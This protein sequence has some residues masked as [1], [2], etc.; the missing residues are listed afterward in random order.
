MPWETSWRLV[1]LGQSIGR[2]RLPGMRVT[3]LD[4]DISLHDRS[5]FDSGSDVVNVWLDMFWDVVPILL[6]GN[7]LA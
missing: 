5:K 2:F 1:I 4:L 7:D 6:L 3:T